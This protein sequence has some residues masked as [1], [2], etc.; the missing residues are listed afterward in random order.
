MDLLAYTLGITVI[1]VIVTIISLAYYNK[2]RAMKLQQLSENQYQNELVR[3]QRDLLETIRRQQGMTFKYTKREDRYI[4]TLCEGELVRKLGF[5]PQMIVGKDIRD[6]LPGDRANCI[7]NAYREAWNGKVTYYEEQLNGIDFYVS[8]SP[9]IEEGKT[10]EVI[11]SAVDISAR[12]RAEK[13]V[14]ENEEFLKKILKQMSEGVMIYKENHE[15]VALNDNVYKILGVT[16][17]EFHKRTID[18]SDLPYIGE[19]ELPLKQEEL[20]ASIALH[21]G[22][23]VK[24]KVVG[25]RSNEKVKWI[26]FN[27]KL[28]KQEGMPTVL[29]TM[30]DIT[31]QKEQ[32]LKLKESNALRRTLI[33]S[34]PI[35]ILVCDVELKTIV[36]NRPFC[37]IFEVSDP[38]HKMIGKIPNNILLN[39]F[40][41]PEKERRQI[42]D[43]IS[44]REPAVDEIL[45][46]DNRV[47]KV[48]Y[49][50]FYMDGELKGHLWTIE[51][52]TKSKVLERRIIAAKEEAEKANLAK[53]EFLS[54]M[55]HEL[56][57]PLNGILGFSQLLEIEQTL[58]LQ[59]HMFVLEIL[60]G[61]RHLLSLINDILDLSRI[62][63]GQV[64][65][66]NH[67]V[68]MNT[69]LEEC[70]NLI[71]PRADEKEIQ[72]IKD[73]AKCPDK[74]VYVDQTRLK[75]IILNLVEN[76]IKYNYQN[77]MVTISCECEKGFLV[78]HVIDN[79]IGIP[80]EEQSLIFEPFYR[81]NNVAVEGTGIGLSLVKQLIYLMGGTIEVNSRVGEGSD[82]SFS[83]PIID[84]IQNVDAL[85]NRNTPYL[86]KVKKSRVLYIED[87]SSNIQLVETV[88]E[89]IKE[90]TLLTAKNGLEGLQVTKEGDIDLVLLDIHLPDMNGMEVIEELKS[91]TTTKDIPVI[92]LS[93]NAIP[94]H[95][96][97]ALLKGAKEYL[98]K[99]IDINLLLSV[100]LKYLS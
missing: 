86:S 40:H 39:I 54:N 7:L 19:D 49:F 13:I 32:E 20:P 66:T 53:S 52:I 33:D 76:A 5:S 28:L 71:K 77:G 30:T 73:D 25:Y 10:I 85:T 56:R 74:M 14:E 62:E 43:H 4:Y 91:T 97:K 60:K 3:T 84:S 37:R 79:G 69:V 21:T 55:S 59:Q 24:G 34:L 41:D 98:T 61:G 87:H 29:L 63:L 12:K 46:K 18:R 99:P 1:Y 2:S 45:T 58:T 57:T 38:I 35:G 68:K 64:K 51:D 90:I 50:P 9:V 22:Q 8:L 11:G 67:S 26:S 89:P 100:V 82:F 96:D 88:L 48:S 83:L 36:L 6:L 92:V 70:I 72:I 75:Q 94:D 80:Q 15:K 78:I 17:E 47:L 31:I 42:L 95:I 16:E 65:L 93:A 81:V 44:K 27:S 23:I